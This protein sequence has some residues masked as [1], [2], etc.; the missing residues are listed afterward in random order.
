MGRA[1][2]LFIALITLV[3][4]S[5][6]IQIQLKFEKAAAYITRILIYAAC[7][8]MLVLLMVNMAMAASMR[9]LFL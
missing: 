8:I 9:K 1:E 7:F 4:L 5:L 3:Q 6:K 2:E